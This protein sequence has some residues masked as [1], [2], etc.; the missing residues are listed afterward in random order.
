VMVGQWTT[1][2][3]TMPGTFTSVPNTAEPSTLGARSMRRTLWPTMRLVLAKGTVAGA[4]VA[5]TLAS[6]EENGLSP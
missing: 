6:T 5:A 3:N 4:V 1:L 2:A